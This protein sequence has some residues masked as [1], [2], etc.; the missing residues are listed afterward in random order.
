MRVYIDAGPVLDYLAQAAPGASGLRSAPRR[1]RAPSAL[2]DDAVTLLN[3]IRASHR[4]ATSAMTFY[5]VEE[6][7]FKQ[8]AANTRGFVNAAAIRVTAARPIVAQALVAADQ[9][10]LD[11][12]RV[13]EET[14][15]SLATDVV[16]SSNAVRAA[17]GMHVRCA[18]AFDADI[19]VT[20]DAGLLALDGVVARPTG[21]T[22]QCCD[23][24]KAL[25]LI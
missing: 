20:G 15:R 19:I 1:G 22:V 13:D 8:V 4:G 16:L 12:V 24:D 25:T 2:F 23:T 14:I 17:D 5:E 3:R 18:V 6:A 21:M 9:F 11:I 7:L 10:G